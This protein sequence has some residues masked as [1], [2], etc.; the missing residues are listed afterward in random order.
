MRVVVLGAG[1][2]GTSCAIQLLRAGFDVII[3]ERQK[4]P[5][6]LPGETLHPG[7]EALLKQLHILDA[8]EAKNFVR[9]QGISVVSNNKENFQYYNEEAKWK[10]FQLYRIDFDEILLRKAVEL[11][12]QYQERVNTKGIIA[13]NGAI[14]AIVTNGKTIAADIFIDATGKRAWLAQQLKIQY[15]TYSPKMVVYYGYVYSTQKNTFENP[16]LIWDKK[17]WTWISK[18]TNCIISWNRLY[19]FND[20]NLPKNWL[21][22]DLRKH[23]AIAPRKAVDVTWRIANQLSAE[24]YFLVGDCAFIVDPSSSHGVIKALMSGIM[25]AYLLEL[26][27]NDKTTRIEMHNYYQ[28]WMS[29]WFENDVQLLKKKYFENGVNFGV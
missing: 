3:I 26:E 9:H 11:G 5:R 16:K 21:P 4:F 20:S 1:P 8:V 7:A 29:L 28:R 6:N 24:N 14:K 25:I 18:V 2:A 27:T 15:K 13:E 10:G 23:Q 19:L 22:K 12:V 17:G